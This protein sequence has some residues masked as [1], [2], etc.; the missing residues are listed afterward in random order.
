MINLT[1]KKW[2]ALVILL[3]M[4]WSGVL[5]SERNLVRFELNDP[6][7][8]PN[9]PSES[10]DIDAL[11]QIS[12]SLELESVQP[13]HSKGIE[14]TIRVVNKG[15]SAVSILDPVG[16]THFV[17]L[18]A[19]GVDV[20]LPVPPPKEVINTGDPDGYAE[21]C[22]RRMPFVIKEPESTARPAKLKCTKDIIDGK[23][24]LNPG[25]E[26][27]VTWYV[28]AVLEDPESPQGGTVYDSPDEDEDAHEDVTKRLRQ[29]P[30]PAGGYQL[31]V[32]VSLRTPASQ[33]SSLRSSPLI[34]VRLGEVP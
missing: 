14:W 15:V 30:I 27:D 13:E 11:N 28:T 17:L 6:A 23:V 5:A 25:D 22:K 9:N 29:I 10:R 2:L 24:Y 4:V 21:H 12:V 8:R 3:C 31:S 20:T 33:H 1:E 34:P 7:A 16:R 32:A 26:F 19:K 18:D